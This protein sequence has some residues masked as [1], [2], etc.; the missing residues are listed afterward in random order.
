MTVLAEDLWIVVVQRAV[1]EDPYEVG[2]REKAA[3]DA[4]AET[5]RKEHPMWTVSVRP[6]SS[7]PQLLR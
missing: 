3:A 7:R 1:G 2:P 4:F 5:A 6:E